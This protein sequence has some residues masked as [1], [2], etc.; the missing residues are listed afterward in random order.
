MRLGSVFNHPLFG[1]SNYDGNKSSMTD[2]ER[3]NMDLGYK[4]I[5]FIC[6]R[7]AYY[8]ER[9]LF[10]SLPHFLEPKLSTVKGDHLPSGKRA[11]SPVR[12]CP[13]QP[14]IYP[15]ILSIT[16]MAWVK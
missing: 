8:R 2:V 1:W 9:V 12:H 4:D 14:S 5:L 3:R 15:K 16:A 11:T 13:H 10:F 7:K 6:F